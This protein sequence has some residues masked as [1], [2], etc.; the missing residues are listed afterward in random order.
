M[1]AKRMHQ[2]MEDIESDMNDDRRLRDVGARLDG[3]ELLRLSEIFVNIARDFWLLER[4]APERKRRILSDVTVQAYLLF[5]WELGGHHLWTLLHHLEDA[6]LRGAMDPY[7]PRLCD[8]SLIELWQAGLLEQEKTLMQAIGVAESA[9][10]RLV[11]EAERSKSFLKDTWKAIPYL[12]HF[13]M[14]L[15]ETFNLVGS[16][17]FWLPM[18]QIALGGAAIGGDA[19]FVATCGVQVGSFMSILS[20]LAWISIW[21]EK[22]QE[23]L[24]R[25]ED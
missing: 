24:R 7:I 8:I 4:R 2:L 23:R 12:E 9:Q 11:S 17:R 18:F 6:G 20:G 19:A 1:T 13:H 3:Q 15:S 21:A 5:D 25:L 22:G 10:M 14:W 16:H